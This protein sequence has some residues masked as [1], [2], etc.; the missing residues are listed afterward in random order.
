[1]EEAVTATLRTEAMAILKG[2][3]MAALKEG[4]TEILRTE[5][6]A[7]PREGAAMEVLSTEVSVLQAE[8]H[9]TATMK[10]VASEVVTTEVSEVQNRQEGVPLHA[11]RL[12]C[13]NLQANLIHTNSTLLTS[14][15]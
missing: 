6:M 4:V 7:T 14:R 10:A 13:V 2:E 12:L 5:A 1:M 9:L 8:E 15:T 3:V 11:E